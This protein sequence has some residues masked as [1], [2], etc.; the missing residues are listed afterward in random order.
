M[1]FYYEKVDLWK[2]NGFEWS[3]CLAVV[4]VLNN[5]MYMLSFFHFYITL[6][7]VLAWLAA[8]EILLDFY[9]IFSKSK[10]ALNN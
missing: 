1:L 10:T 3:K 8:V 5:S 2:K 4:F 9:L 6:L 7:I